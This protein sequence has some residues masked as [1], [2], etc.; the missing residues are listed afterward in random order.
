MLPPALASSVITHAGSV[1]DRPHWHGPRSFTLGPSAIAR[2][3]RLAIA[4]WQAPISALTARPRRADEP[5]IK[6]SDPPR[7]RRRRS[8]GRPIHIRLENC[9][10]AEAPRFALCTAGRQTEIAAAKQT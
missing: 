4:Q 10:L 1:R 3:A 2:S 9:R 5:G 7:P 8:P 6:D